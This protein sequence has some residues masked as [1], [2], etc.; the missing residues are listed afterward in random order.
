MAD[1]SWTASTYF[2]L[3]RSGLA[4]AQFRDDSDLTF[5]LA[6][7]VKSRYAKVKVPGCN[8]LGDFLRS[9]VLL[10]VL[11]SEIFD[12]WAVI[13]RTLSNDF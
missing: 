6:H 12:C 5:G 9:Q 10:Q 1:C 11:D 4:V 7:P 2:D 8:V 13:P 3:F